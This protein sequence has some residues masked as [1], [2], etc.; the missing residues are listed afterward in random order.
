MV[1][2]HTGRKVS[3]ERKVGECDRRKASGQCSRG[4]SCRFNHGSN[5]GQNAQAFSLAPKT[6]TQMDGR[7]PSKGFGSRE[8]VFLENKTRKGAKKSSKEL[9]RIRRKIM[10]ILPRVKITNL[11]RDANFGNQC[12]DTLRLMGSPVSRRSGVAAFLI[13]SQF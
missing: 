1:T 13:E 10:G 3:V 11:N 6:Q 4:D 2:G 7:K 12:L 9:A 8:K 5:R